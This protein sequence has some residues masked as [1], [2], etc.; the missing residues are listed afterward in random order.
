M[1]QDLLRKA[2]EY[3]Q[4]WVDNMFGDEID[5]ERFGLRFEVDKDAGATEIKRFISTEEYS[6]RSIAESEDG[7]YCG[8]PWEDAAEEAM[9]NVFARGWEDAGMYILT[10]NG[11]E[12]HCSGY[13]H[14][15]SALQDVY[16]HAWDLFVTYEAQKP[17]AVPSA[18]DLEAAWQNLTDS[19]EDEH[20]ELF[21]RLGWD[22]AA[23]A[24]D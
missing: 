19:F 22:D 5:Q 23:E 3:L 16:R 21:K 10:A 6:T 8:I 14:L 7:D 20:K 13:V 18:E 12:T 15:K 4:R 1:K 24:R 9:W 17:V 2:Q 11:T